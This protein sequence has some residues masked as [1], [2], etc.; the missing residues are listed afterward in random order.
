MES[1]TIEGC[2]IGLGGGLH[3]QYISSIKAD[4]KSTNLKPHTN[5]IFSLIHNLV[6][7]QMVPLRK[8]VLDNS[9]LNCYFNR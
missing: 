3:S 8:D 1:H 7:A 5:E 4:S 2:A 6:L 9:A